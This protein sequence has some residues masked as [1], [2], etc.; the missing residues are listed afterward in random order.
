MT[1]QREINGEAARRG[2]R[3]KHAR[4]PG[5]RL[6]PFVVETGGRL[7]GEAR[8]WLRN[9]VRQL[10]EDQQTSELARAYRLVSCAVQ[11]Q[12]ARQLRRS[13]GLR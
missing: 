4:Y 11:G 12:I 5:S 1:L 3:E 13:A 10:P 7:G 8:L 2:E 9:Q 6:V